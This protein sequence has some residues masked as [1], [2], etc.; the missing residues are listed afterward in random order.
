MP[1]PVQVQ[2]F[3]PQSNG[4][5]LVEKGKTMATP[6]QRLQKLLIC[7]CIAQMVVVAAIAVVLVVF[8]QDYV[9]L[10]FCIVECFS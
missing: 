6:S 3:H 8:V 4:N 7:L 1:A 9:S 10:I 2:P 5:H